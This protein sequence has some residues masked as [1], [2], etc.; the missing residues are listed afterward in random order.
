MVTIKGDEGWM[1]YFEEFVVSDDLFH[2]IQTYISWEEKNHFFRLMSATKYTFCG[3]IPPNAH[4]LVEILLQVQSKKKCKWKNVSPGLAAKILARTCD[5]L[6]F[7][8]CGILTRVIPNFANSLFFLS[9]R[10]FW[11]V[12]EIF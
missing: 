5:Q 8:Q 9:S 3:D 12:I 4:Q 6:P 11:L 10:C 1:L 2:F 7:H